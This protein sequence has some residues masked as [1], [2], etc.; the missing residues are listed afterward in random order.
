MFSISPVLTVHTPVLKLPL[1][2][3]NAIYTYKAFP[4]LHLTS[5]TEIDDKAE[6]SP[7]SAPRQALPIIIETCARAS[8]VNYTQP[9]IRPRVLTRLLSTSSAG[10]P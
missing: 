4:V 7:G 3:G 6:P 1:L 2:L 10:C 9:R 8:K 5:R